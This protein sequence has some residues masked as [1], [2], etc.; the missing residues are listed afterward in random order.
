MNEKRDFVKLKKETRKIF[1][2]F[3][4][5]NL[6]FFHNFLKIF[7]NFIKFILLTFINLINVY[8]YHQILFIYNYVIFI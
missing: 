8:S 5:L 3:L 2:I 7:F 1:E 4:N 6:F